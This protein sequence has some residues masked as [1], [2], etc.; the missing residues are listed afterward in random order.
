MI[1][2]TPQQIAD[3]AWSLWNEYYSEDNLGNAEA[4]S[5]EDIRS[6]ITADI[7]ALLPEKLDNNLYYIRCKT[8]GMWMPDHYS[9]RPRTYEEAYK[10]IEDLN[11][12]NTPKEY[13]MINIENNQ[14]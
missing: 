12:H 10:L 1:K 14:L 4:L 3:K 6:I 11:V 9:G 2:L 13:E 8:D 7:E 5:G